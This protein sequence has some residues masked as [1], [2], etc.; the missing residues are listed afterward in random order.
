MNV[1]PLEI[2]STVAGVFATVKMIE[3][4]C[5]LVSFAV[6]KMWL[7]AAPFSAVP[8]S[9]NCRRLVSG[10]CALASGAAVPLYVAK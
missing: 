7:V 6:V 8:F 4:D 9:V 1:P 10:S 5:A 2:I 3:A